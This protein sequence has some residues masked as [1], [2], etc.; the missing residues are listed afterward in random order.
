MPIYTREMSQ[1]LQLIPLS[2]PAHFSTTFYH[3]CMPFE[4]TNCNATK[5]SAGKEKSGKAYRNAYVLLAPNCSGEKYV[6]QSGGG[7]HLCK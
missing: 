3:L 5:V 1:S 6:N 7:E 2:S 4:S